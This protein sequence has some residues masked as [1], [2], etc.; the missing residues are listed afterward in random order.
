M[1]T[2]FYN[3][4]GR[5]DDYKSILEARTKPYSVACKDE[6]T[7]ATSLWFVKEALSSVNS[8][9]SKESTKKNEFMTKVVTRTDEAFVLWTLE[10]SKDGWIKNID[11]D[12]TIDDEEIAQNRFGSERANEQYKKMSAA[13]ERTRASVHCED[14]DRQMMGHFRDKYKRKES[15]MEKPSKNKKVRYEKNFDLLVDDFNF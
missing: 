11:A 5:I 10:T 3:T 4:G 7:M 15:L 8:N 9:W 1:V 6:D 14:W 2:E 12:K 13:V